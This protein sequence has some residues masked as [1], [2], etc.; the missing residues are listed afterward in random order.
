MPAPNE[1]IY[2]IPIHRMAAEQNTFKYT[3]SIYQMRQGDT[4]NGFLI[5]IMIAAALMI[6]AYF[7][8]FFKRTSSFR[9]FFSA[10]MLLLIALL[11]AAWIYSIVI[12]QHSIILLFMAVIFI[13]LHRLA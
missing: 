4:M 7:T 9:R 12:G 3:E 2:R 8:Y 13:V 11:L 1:Y 10:S 6:I 5:A